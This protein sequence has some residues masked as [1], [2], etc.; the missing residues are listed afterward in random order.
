M[1]AWC[2]KAGHG[3]RVMPAGTLLGAQLLKAPDYVQIT[4]LIDQ[5]KINIAAG[6][7]GGELDPHGQDLVRLLKLVSPVVEARSRHTFS[8]VTLSADSCT[9]INFPEGVAH[10]K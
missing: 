9:R 2:T 1:V 5:T 8:V 10:A 6:D 4:G 7:Y 3:T